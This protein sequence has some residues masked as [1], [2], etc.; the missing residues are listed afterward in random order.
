MAAPTQAV[1]MTRQKIA[2]NEALKRVMVARL[3]LCA[4]LFLSAQPALAELDAK[5]Q[6]EVD[7]LLAF[8]SHSPCTF[9]RNGSAYSAQDAAAH[10]R[11]KLDYLTR[12]GRVDTAEQFIERAASESSLSGKP[13]TVKCDGREQLSGDWLREELLRVRQAVP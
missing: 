13:Y 10:L 3:A 1:T 7:A 12:R 11:Q 6:R 4:V 8:V 9:I 5:G 2:M